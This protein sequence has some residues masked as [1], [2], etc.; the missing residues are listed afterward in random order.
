MKVTVLAGGTS[1]ER[2]VSLNS[3]L[4]V[5][6]TLRKN[7]HTVTVLDPGAGWIEIDPGAAP[8][9]TLQKLCSLP[10]A[11]GKDILTSGDIVFNML[12]GGQGENGIVCA[13]LELLGVPYVGSRPGASAA[14]MDKVVSKRLFSA[15]GVPV[16]DYFVLNRSLKQRWQTRIEAGIEK[17]GL[18]AIVKPAE[19]GST[20]GL[21][22]AKTVDQVYQAVELAASL[23]RYVL[24]EKFIAGRELTVG[25]LGDE[26]LPVL[27]VVIP[28]GFYDFEA[29]YHGQENKYICPAEIDTEVAE[30]VQQLALEAFRVL[31][32]D[33]YARI[34]FR[35]D[36]NN[37]LWC[38]EANN[39]PGMT[40]HSL[41]PK[42]ALVTGL[43]LTAL[44]ERLI[45]NALSRFRSG[46]SSQSASKEF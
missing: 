9:E 24:V 31:D 40:D 18:P 28:G 37:E 17:V 44:L 29:K 25:V 33:D 34:D 42:A 2:E 27:E 1:A 12:H 43:D 41:L 8:A 4:C 19:E 21:T 13:V 38:L 45:K 3:A 6:Q 32:L 23:S 30:R 39:Q 5:V 35:L 20:V 7:G 46:H 36:E 16:P 26:A 10:E 11:G 15:V 14:A 22:K